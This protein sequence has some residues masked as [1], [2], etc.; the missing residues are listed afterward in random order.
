[1][2]IYFYYSENKSSYTFYY[3]DFT[4]L[5]VLIKLLKRDS[6]IFSI[7]ML[8]MWRLAGKQMVLFL[9]KISVF[10]GYLCNNYEF[11]VNL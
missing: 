1:V 8:D 4:L 9:L 5:F 6:L 10:H 3:I 7:E 11:I 2:M